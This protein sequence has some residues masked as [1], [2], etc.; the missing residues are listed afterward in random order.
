MR[1]MP[2]TIEFKTPQEGQLLNAHWQQFQRAKQ[3]VELLLA[4]FFASRGEQD[5]EVESVTEAGVRLAGHDD[6]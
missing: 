4:A 1:R 5:Y 6:A 3:N 2:K